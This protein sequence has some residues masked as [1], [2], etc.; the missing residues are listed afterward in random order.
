MITVMI[1]GTSTGVYTDTDGRYIIPVPNPGSAVLVF[2]G[3]GY[4]TVE[5]PVNGRTTIDVTIAADAM[6]LDEVIVT[7]YGNMRRSEY[8]GSASSVNMTKMETIPTT[9]VGAK[10]AGATSGVQI[11][12]TSGMPGANETIRIRGMG[13][14]NASN[15]PLIVLDGIPML[16]GNGAR[17][18]YANSGTSL[19]STINSSDIE[20]MTVI[21]DAAAASLYGSRAANGVI[22]IT[23]K[24]GRSGK[25]QFSFSAD[26][27]IS[28]VA[29]GLDNWRPTK[30]GPERYDLL[31]TAYHNK[32]LRDP[33]ILQAGQTAE[34]YATAQANT[35]G[36][37]PA[38]GWEDW[39]GLFFKKGS[40]QN[41]KLSVQAGNDKTKVYASLAYSKHEGITM[42][43]AYDRYTG[44]VNVEHKEG[45][46]TM[47]ASAN[48]SISEQKV[49]MEGTS[50]GSPLM[51][52]A[53]TTTPSDFAYNPNGTIN[54]TTGFKAFPSAMANPLNT[55]VHNWDANTIHRTMTT[56]FANYDILPELA[57]RQT[58]AYDFINSDN[59]VWW[60]PKSNDGRTANGVFQRY[61]TNNRSF[62]SKT[63]L[64]YM[65]TFANKHNLDALVAYEIEDRGRI[66]MYVNGQDYPTD[67]LYE[68]STAAVTRA[69][70][71]H[72]GSR[73]ISYVGRVNYNYN[74]RYYFGVSFRR[75]G[76]SRMAPDE[77]WGN[78][79]SVSGSW[80]FMNE[81]F[82]SGIKHIL[83][84][85]KLRASYGINGTMPN[86]NYD[87]F[88]LYGLGYK[89]AGAS[90]MIQSSVGNEIL[91]W[92]K[93]NAANIGAELL[94]FNRISLNVDWYNR[95]TKDLIFATPLSRT[96]G[97]ST[98]D[99]NV[100]KMN[101]KGIEIELRSVNVDKNGFSWITSVNVSHNKNKVTY[102][103]D[104]VARGTGY[105]INSNNIH[106]H[107][108]GDPYYSYYL[109]EYAGVDPATGQES[110]YIN[111]SGSGRQT[112][113]KPADADK[114]L[115]GTPNPKLTGGI[116]N[117]LQWK[118][119]DLN[120]TFTYSL[121]GKVLDRA[122]WL[123]TNGGA[124]PQ[125]NIAAFN[126][127]ND[128]WK[129]S[130]DNAKLP[131]YDH[132]LQTVAVASTRWML[133]TD[134][135][136]LKN[137]A[138]GYTLPASVSKAASLSKV[139]V[140]MSASNLLTF[141]SKKLYFDPEGPI[142]GLYTYQTPPLKT[143]TFGLE[144]LF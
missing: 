72:S 119:F 143:V 89:Y 41:Y 132:G 39:R 103:S 34:Q 118:G 111:R 15:E 55:L 33:T 53:M 1:K 5:L 25:A 76:S 129:Q 36:S 88:K 107:R 61:S 128:M 114:I 58:I 93:N 47:G 94:F 135:L 70:G 90:G 10:L 12:S 125:Y 66:S 65:K 83:T 2:A 43:S 14:I 140:Y 13:S 92:E 75:D 42:R 110:Y 96:S 57:I 82:L 134:H 130:G 112:T 50:Y 99:G 68:T 69:S 48:F 59:R 71:D 138:F 46:F 63:T 23:T 105:T 123:Q 32:A 17:F 7:G 133:P 139:R 22:V 102:L 52:V 54:T 18:S 73:L 37:E 106:I 35:Y 122:T 45:K 81:Q 60:S 121:G 16:S 49:N 79:W 131:K 98:V 27:G 124:N 78:F 56:A 28:D 64:S 95:D 24:K 19:L 126:N 100:A 67:K 80:R 84:D 26:A 30:N 85:G 21:K 137:L 108:I 87:Y 142:D 141:K 86:G 74:S 77:R 120:F 44:F 38:T 91:T 115:I 104:E 11:T 3:I 109:Y 117:E 113:L 101:N 31:Y 29:I 9:S 20:T 51:G 136:R 4:T 127:P 8:T 6:Q 62:T 116:S 144:I 40:F 97:F